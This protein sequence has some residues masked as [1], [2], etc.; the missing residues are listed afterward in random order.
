MDAQRSHPRKGVVLAPVSAFTGW[1]PRRRGTPYNPAAMSSPDPIA[2]LARHGFVVVTGKGGVG[3]ST[4]SAVLARRLTRG[5]AA[6]DRRV[7]VVEVDPRESL[8]RLLGAP[9]S[10][11]EIVDVG[12]GLSLQHL[13]PR[14]VV[15]RVI[16]ERIRIGA[17]VRKVQSSAVYEH[18]V[19]GAPG[20][21][22]LAILEH[23]RRLLDEGRFELVILD[24]PA[25][26]HGVSMLRAP[27]LVAE[28]VEGGPFGRIAGEIAELVADPE[29]CAVA[30]VTQAEEMP[31]HEALELLRMMDEQLGRRPDLL[32]VN[33]LYP[34][35]PADEGADDGD[36][37]SAP[38]DLVDLW[39]RRRAVNLRE[40]E[41]LERGWP[42]GMAGRIELPL[43]PLGRGPELVAALTRCLQARSQA[44]RRGTP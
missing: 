34:A 16:E 26:G 11:G 19:D 15:D 39:R 13:K 36:L 23:A 41:R 6:G 1:I 24:A 14:A 43:L 2:A 4:V 20:L 29:R 27:L 38:D 30:V 33:G 28:V 17:V 32:V 21:K 40:L 37:K 18:F 42:E 22:E 5:G 12:G 31:V 3:K 25:T 7:L 8:H 35:L 44:R 9:P 10:G